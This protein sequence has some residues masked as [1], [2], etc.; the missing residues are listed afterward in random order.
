MVKPGSQGQGLQGYSFSLLWAGTFLSK[1]KKRKKKNP[2]IPWPVCTISCA[3]K[4][5][6]KQ[7]CRTRGKSFSCP[8]DG[9]RTRPREE[10]N[11]TGYCH[12]VPH[13]WNFRP[14]TRKKVMN[15]PLTSFQATLTLSPQAIFAPGIPRGGG[16]FCPR[17]FLFDRVESSYS[18]YC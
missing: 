8:R 13:L 2:N 4:L 12:T 6:P 7:R 9:L 1:K 5:Q 15:A 14:W 3:S 11:R 10:V 17:I 18:G 16:G